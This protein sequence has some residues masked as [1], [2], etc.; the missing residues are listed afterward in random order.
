MS[1]DYYW[2]VPNKMLATKRYREHNVYVKTVC[3]KDKLLV[4]NIKDGWDP[5]CK[6]LGLEKPDIPWPNEN[7]GGQIAADIMTCPDA[8]SQR[9]E[10]ISKISVFVMLVA[11][12]VYYLYQH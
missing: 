11:W 2:N 9:R 5:V 12:G 3:P 10:F 1:P 6:F 4:F 8:C 7:K